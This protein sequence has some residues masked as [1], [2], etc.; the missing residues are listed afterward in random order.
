MNDLKLNYSIPT[1]EELI[2]IIEKEDTDEVLLAKDG[3]WEVRLWLADDGTALTGVVEI[4]N[5]KLYEESVL[6][7]NDKLC[8]AFSYN[9][10]T[11]SK[12]ELYWVLPSAVEE[13]RA[14]I[15]HLLNFIETQLLKKN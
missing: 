1:K 11:F 7:Y 12:S 6:E 3:D 10:R 15:N 2:R 5:E 14:Y 4:T 9:T 8:D 13:C